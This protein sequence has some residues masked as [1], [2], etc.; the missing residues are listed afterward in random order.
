MKEFF[1]NKQNLMITCVAAVLLFVGI[2]IGVFLDWGENPTNTEVA[3]VEGKKITLLCLG[4]DK[5]VAMDERH[6]ETNSIGQADGIFLISIDTGTKE[7]DI[8]AIPRDTVVTIE[9]Y[10]HKLQYMGREEAQICLQYA[11]ADGMEYSCELTADRVNDLFPDTTIDG[12]ISINIEA[13]MEINDAVGGV[14]V[15]VE[16]EYTALNM[17]IPVGTT[18]NLMGDNTMLYL[19]LR[20]KSVNGSAYTRMNRIKEYITLFIPQGLSAIKEDP[21]LLVEMYQTLDEHMVTNVEVGDFAEIA[22]A[23]SDLD[24]ENVHFHTLQGEI[25]LADDGYEEFY[26]DEAQ[27]EMLRKKMA[28]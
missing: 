27:M 11:Y 4:V 23:L 28:D 21:T 3:P 14:E 25:V 20:D 7:V 10:N 12:Y 16:D 24:M 13:I 6:P 8:V 26:P 5:Q 22:L 15:M 18:L 9:K 2:A 19:R 1:S 17:G